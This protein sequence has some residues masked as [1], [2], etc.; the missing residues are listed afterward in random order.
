MAASALAILGGLAA[1]ERAQGLD[2][3]SVATEVFVGV[4]LS[5]AFEREAHLWARKYPELTVVGYG[6]NAR[7][8]PENALA[9]AFQAEREAQGEG[10]PN[11]L[12]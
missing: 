3:Q 6:Y 4:V 12:D 5:L 11:L 2:G 7:L 10:S 8:R 9:R 1:A